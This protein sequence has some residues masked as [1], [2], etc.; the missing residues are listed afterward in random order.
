MKFKHLWAT[1]TLLGASAVTAQNAAPPFRIVSTN[2]AFWRLD[3]AVRAVGA[4]TDTILIAPGTYHECATQHDGQISFKATVPGGAVFDGQ[5]CEGKAALV[6]HGHGARVDGLVFENM[7]VPD[8]NGAGIRLETGNLTV[9]NSL[10]RNSEEGILSADDPSATVV[11]DHSTFAG[12]GRCDRGLSCAHAIYFGNVASL[13]VTHSRFERGQGGH[14]VK[15][16]A[17]HNVLTD[18]SF[19]DSHGHTTNYMVDL[20][21]GSVGQ[22]TGNMFVQG[23]DK[24]NHSALITVAAEERL[25]RSAGLV[26]SGNRASQAPGADWPTV[27]VADWSHEPLRIGTNTLSARIKPFEQR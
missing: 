1:A 20:C 7:R 9:V 18:N 26:I 23:K 17:A 16:R 15:S 8:G 12:L 19:D 10:F 3:D 2:Q 13:T 11:I 21:A 24:E 22:V 5:I 27:F 6:L 14:Y 4:H 25:H